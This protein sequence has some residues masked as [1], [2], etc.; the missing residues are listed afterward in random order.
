MTR[1]YFHV[2]STEWITDK[3][4]V[5]IHGDIDAI[6]SVATEKAVHMM[7]T[8]ALDG[9][10]VSGYR[11]EVENECGEVVLHLAFRGVLMEP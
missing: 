4:G 10:D 6:R 11:L 5:V 2:R 7:R 3:D 9:E 1:Y 8:A